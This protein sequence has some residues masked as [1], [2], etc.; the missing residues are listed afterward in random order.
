MEKSPHKF[1]A[2]EI[3]SAIIGDIK[4]RSTCY[5][6]ALA[7]ESGCG[8]TET[9]KELTNALT[10]AG[11][12][13]LVL[14][15]DNYFYL[16]PA[17]NDAKRKSDKT[18][19]GPR[20]EVDLQLLDNIIVAAKNGAEELAVQ[21]IDYASGKMTVDEVKMNGIKVIIVE[22]TYTMLLKHVD[23]R[24]FIDADYHDTLPY[25]I[26]RNR[27]NEVRDPFVENILETEHKI[28]AGHRFLADFVISKDYE[29]EHIL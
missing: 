4:G 7:G 1:A 29:V 2:G 23:V 15:Q 14:G 25:R 26:K 22:G 24:I 28:I 11:I 8:K 13:S 10:E 18:W 3:V 19:L 9:S 6:V 27:G 17:A 20:K 5:V 21:F 16:P 12:R